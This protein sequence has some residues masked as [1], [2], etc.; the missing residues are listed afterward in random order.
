MPRLEPRSSALRRSRLGA[1]TAEFADS[2]VHLVRAGDAPRLQDLLERGVD[3]NLQNDRG[4]SLLLLA[5]YHGHLEA[6]RV[7]LDHGAHPGRANARG[8]TPLAGAAFKDDAAM[9]ELLLEHGADVDGAA[10]DG[11]TPLMLAAM[12]D[13]EEIV[14]VLLSH[15]A[16]P[17]V[18][19]VQGLTARDYAARMGAQAALA[20]LAS[21]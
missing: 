7:L 18:R 21:E 10:P 6:A 20:R 4:D 11:Q 12:Y 1:E 2:I 15:G 9:V 17:Q 19:D 16:D 13:R 14:D 8:Q 3:P 5:S